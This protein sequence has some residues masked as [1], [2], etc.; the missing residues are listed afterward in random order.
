[1]EAAI[2]V[3][4]SLL[5]FCSLVRVAVFYWRKRRLRL[6]KSHKPPSTHDEGNSS[7]R[8]NATNP[9]ST[10]DNLERGLHGSTSHR[11]DAVR[12]ED[13]QGDGS[14]A[15]SKEVGEGEKV[16]AVGAGLKSAVNPPAPIAEEG[17]NGHR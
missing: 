7:E 9:F 12:E 1:M 4:L 5:L 15:Y 13:V 14:P 6:L 2:I 11:G 10:A 16:L 8:R 3:V 17:R